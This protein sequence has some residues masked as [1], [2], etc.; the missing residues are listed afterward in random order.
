MFTMKKLIA[1]I[2]VVV[3]LNSCTEKQ[4]DFSGVNP[5]MRKEDVLKKIGEPDKKN[6]L[7]FAELWT[8]SAADRTVVFRSDTV[9]DILTSTEARID[10]LEM[11]LK[12]TGSKLREKIDAGVD[13]LD[14]GSLNI[15][16]KIID[17]SD[18]NK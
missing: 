8:Y 18:T 15:K 2:S 9:Y 3:L 1:M 13:S 5:G 14:S 10:S 7:V 17:K 4:K 16:N 12:E 6:D 11:N